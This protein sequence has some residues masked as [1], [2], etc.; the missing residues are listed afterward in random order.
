MRGHER[1]PE[2]CLRYAGDDSLR[3]LSP[4]PRRADVFRCCSRIVA[5][6]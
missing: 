3:R 5:D 2:R 6:G 4:L 1:R